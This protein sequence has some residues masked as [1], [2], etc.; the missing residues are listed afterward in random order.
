M[1]GANEP[2]GV[3]TVQWTVNPQPG[4]TFVHNEFNAQIGQVTLINLPPGNTL[5]AGRIVE[6]QIVDSGLPTSH[7]IFTARVASLGATGPLSG[8]TII[9]T[10]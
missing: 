4:N 3:I 2:F 6:V 9:P 1:P 7:A 10:P 8:V 5:V